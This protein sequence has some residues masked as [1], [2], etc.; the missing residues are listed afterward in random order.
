MDI[1]VQNQKGSCVGP[2]G[3]GLLGVGLELTRTTGG[4]LKGRGGSTWVK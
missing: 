2:M 3:T 1:S 4:P